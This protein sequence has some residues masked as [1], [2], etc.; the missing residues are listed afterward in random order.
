MIVIIRSHV[1]AVALVCSQGGGNG[2]DDCCV[3]LLS[4]RVALAAVWMSDYALGH[5]P[6]VW[7][8]Q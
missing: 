5:F 3:L 2:A 8:W 6:I 1:T 7:R 4:V